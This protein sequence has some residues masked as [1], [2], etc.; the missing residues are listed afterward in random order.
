MLDADGGGPVS[1]RVHAPERGK[2]FVK[3]R[4]AEVRRQLAAGVAAPALPASHL[5]IAAGSA[6]E[7]AAMGGRESDAK[8]RFPAAIT[9]QDGERRAVE[10]CRIDHPAEYHAGMRCV[11]NAKP[12]VL[13][14][15]GV[16]AEGKW[17]ESLRAVAAGVPGDCKHRVLANDSHLDRFVPCDDAKNVY[18]SFYHVRE[19]ETQRM[20]M[21]VADFA[22]CAT[23]WTTRKLYLDVPVAQ[24]TP[25]Q[26]GSPEDNGDNGDAV[27][28]A[29]QGFENTPLAKHLLGEGMDWPWIRKLSR[30]QRF[31]PCL[32]LRLVASAR[33][34]L[35]PL[36][37]A[38]DERLLV[39]ALGRSRCLLIPPRHAFRGL[40]PYPLHHP[41]DKHSMVDL[42]DVDERMWPLF[43]ANVRGS[44][45]YLAPGDALYVPRYHFVHIE[46]LDAENAMLSLSFGSGAR[47][48]TPEQAG[49]MVSRHLEDRLVATEQVSVRDVRH[50]LTLIRDGDE[51]DWIDL[52]TVKG[53]RRIVMCQMVR[54]EIESHD[55][56]DDGD[57]P[58]G[59]E[60]E[61]D[62]C[63]PLDPSVRLGRGRWRTFLHAMTDR[64]LEAT[65]WLNAN[66]REPLYLK[67]TPYLLEDDRTEWEKKYPEFFRA[68][69]RSQGWVVPDAVS[70]VPIPGVNVPGGPSV[71]GSSRG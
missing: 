67:D 5:R 51:L 52:D 19:P 21:S 66:F 23:T 43:K 28:R 48:R 2:G 17:R 68:K 60:E 29:A 63:G 59:E 56:G 49:L 20:E 50:W 16:V 24:R 53:Y 30:V 18:G 3:M 45:C 38:T 8:P 54:D 57:E 9:D 37:Y 40:Y 34:S 31:G 14:N 42:E 13:T 1:M 7:D 44:V 26:Y 11:R 36:H 32:D 6:A 71:P 65:P 55:D 35:R 15:S 39:Q 4:Q 41:Y 27:P 12:V 61:E 33:G 58:D 62:A 22:Q 46:S 64:R 10:R 69:L 70:T 47:A 25:D